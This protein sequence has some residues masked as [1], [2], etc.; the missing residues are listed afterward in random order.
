[1]SKCMVGICGECHGQKVILLAH[2]SALLTDDV[3][4]V[5]TPGENLQGCEYVM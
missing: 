1:M 3:D 4:D 5:G 2:S